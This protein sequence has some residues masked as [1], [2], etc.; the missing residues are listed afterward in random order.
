MFLAGLSGFLMSS[1]KRKERRLRSIGRQIQAQIMGVAPTN[2]EV[3]NKPYYR[4]QAQCVNETTNKM[5]VYESFAYPYDP[6]EALKGKEEVTVY[7]NPAN[8][9]DYWMDT[10][11]LPPFS[12]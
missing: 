9:L 11:F 2:F 7:V 1:H 6:T 10:T 5:F 4:V 8:P 3:N 12:K